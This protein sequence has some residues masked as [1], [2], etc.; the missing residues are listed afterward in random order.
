MVPVLSGREAEKASE[1]VGEV[2]LVGKSG[3]Q[4]NF[5]RHNALLQKTLG[6]VD[7]KRFQIAV[8]SEAGLLGESTQQGGFAETGNMADLC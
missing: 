2:T 5:C 6:F 7:A 3:L 4:C 8:W 1:V